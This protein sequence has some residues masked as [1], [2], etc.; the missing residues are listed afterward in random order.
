MSP[1]SWPFSSVPKSLTT[2]ATIQPQ[3]SLFSHGPSQCLLPLTLGSLCVTCRWQAYLPS[4]RLATGL[5]GL[6]FPRTLPAVSQPLPSVS[7]GLDRSGK[8]CFSLLGNGQAGRGW[9]VTSYSARVG[10]SDAGVWDLQIR[11]P[12]VESASGVLSLLSWAQ[13]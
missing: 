10:H 13:R 8:L 3:A 4:G 5:E 7:P 1:Q 6:W 9:L 12:K 2:A 11:K